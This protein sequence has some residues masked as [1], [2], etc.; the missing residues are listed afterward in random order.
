MKLARLALIAVCALTALVAAAVILFTIMLVR[1][2][3]HIAASCRF[4]R[5]IGTV[6]VPASPQPAEASVQLVNDSR[7]AY[8]GLGCGNLPPPSAGL[9]RWSAHYHLTVP[10]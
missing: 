8:T 2:D 1:Q 10:G 3:Q 9:K 4:Y 7:A 5:L 6:T